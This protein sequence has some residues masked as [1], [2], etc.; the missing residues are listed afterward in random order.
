LKVFGGKLGSA[1]RSYFNN[2]AWTKALTN[3]REEAA[4]RLLR[5]ELK[6]VRAR[7]RGGGRRDI[8][9][10][11]DR[12]ARDYSRRLL[13]LIRKKP[14]RLVTKDILVSRYRSSAILDTLMPGRKDQWKNILKRPVSTKSPVIDLK[15]FSFIH[16]PEETLKKIQAIAYIES[17]ALEAHIN[18]DDPFCLDAGAYLALAEI[19]PHLAPIFLG[20]RMSKPIQK[21]L[22]ATGVGQHN[23]MS[24]PAVDKHA[25]DGGTVTYD[26]VWAFPLQ[27]RR[28]ARSSS[29]ATVHL[30][31][32]TREKAV[33]RFCIALNEWIG[34]PEIDRE[35][36]D[37]G[38]GWIAGII[39]ELLC[40]A[41]RHSQAGSDDGDWATTGFMVKRHEN[42][43][44]ILRCHLAF[45]SVGRSFAESLTD[46]APEI[47][48][49][50]NDY[51]TRHRGSGLSRETLATVF[52]LQDTITCDPSAREKRSGGTGL[53]DVL[54]FVHTLG[55][56]IQE[57]KEPSISVISGRSCISLRPPYIPGK[58]KEGPLSPRLLWCNG[59]NDSR[60]P[61]DPAVVMDLSE[62]FAGTLVSVA[63]TLDPLYLAANAESNDAD[64]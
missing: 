53:Q 25:S 48:S 41:E 3:E 28:P 7:I 58:R 55:G 16:A 26:D 17:T 57:G 30:D 52:A 59:E 37:E 47:K 29:S 2:N 32:Q 34:I 9:V 31:P 24:F 51:A 54:E 43:E 14:S 21:V 61:P 62:H 36:T 56:T 64:D 50:I 42:G 10:A 4:E 40:N 44:A 38:K 12:H 1:F 35:L 13:K 23:R 45:L 22:H 63:F 5:Q 49:V 20:G 15:N 18:F 46:A 6:H 19:W 11:R 27:R 60:F 8:R 39:G 33:D